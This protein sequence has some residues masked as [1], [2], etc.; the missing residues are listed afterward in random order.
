[1]FPSI[2]FHK[3]KCN[4][5][6]LG[7]AIYLGSGVAAAADTAT[8]E[9]ASGPNSVMQEVVV[10]GSHIKRAD[11]ETA[12]NVAVIS[13]AEVASSGQETVAD[14]LRTISSA[15]GN[16]SNESFSNSFAPGAASI[17]LRGLSG[18]DTLVL[19]NGR[20]ITNYGFFQNL[21]D[22]FVDLNIIPAAAIDHIEIL[23]SGGSAI[24]GSDA[25]TGVINVILKQN[26]TEKAVE[27]GD[28]VTTDGGANTRDA[29]VRFGIGD[30]ATQ[31]YNVFATG[32]VY[33]RDQLLF[34]QRRNTETQDYRNLPDGILQYHIAN[35]YAQ[36]KT[37]FPNCGTPAAPG[38]VAT[39]SFGP[40]CYYND[41][42]QLSLLPEA[43]RANVTVTGNL[44]LGEHWTGY[45]DLFFSNEETKNNFTPATLSNGSF[46]ASLANNSATQVSNVLPGT[47]RASI[48]GAPTSIIY[49]FQSV[50]GRDAEVVSNT[51]RVTFGAK[52]TF[53]GWDIDGAYGHSEN[54]VSFEAQNSINAAN[55]TADIANGSFN[56]LD[57]TQT[58]QANAALRVQN[59]F[60]SVAKLDSV[61]LNGSRNL[62]NL[63]GGPVKVAA[64]A[65]FRH[66]SV[67]DQPGPAE[68]AGI[69]LNNGA[70][71]VVA[72]RSIEAL[73]GEL[74]LPIVESL[75]LDVALRDEH[76][77]DVGTTPWRPQYT[78]RWQPLRAVT[79]RAVFADGFRAP[80]LAES[81][82]S[83][84][85]AN[86]TIN[87]PLD[88]AHRPTENVGLI[89]GG[90]P[91]V[92]PETSRNLDLGLIVSPI[93]NLDFSIDYYNIFLYDVIAPNATPQAIADN[94]AAYPGQLHRGPDGTIV[95]VEALYTNQFE[96][97]TS[98]LDISSNYSIPL[99]DG[100][101]K[102]GIDTT[103]VQHFQVNSAGTW[104]EFVGSNG[105]DYLSPIAGGG[106][107]PRWKGSL[108]SGWENLDWTGSVSLRYTQGYQ[109]S[110]TGQGITTQKTV[111]S[112]SSVD[113]D[114]QYRGLKDWKFTLSVVNLLNRY[115]PY[116]SAALLFTPSATPYD[117][118]TYDDL[119]RMISLH[120][121]RSF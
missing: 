66:E 41:A 19:L 4:A 96:I 95:Y 98:G 114:G 37:P 77:S 38:V 8:A 54:H 5:A 11:A 67:N 82:R 31:G 79:L 90:N 17:G 73:F 97:H 107:V 50:G 49:G 91:N 1:M 89:T 63:P 111:A 57:P 80:S 83:S 60:A 88:P 103:Y 81:S 22:A 26:T 120:V 74:D 32:S 53:A 69:V 87:D 9:E 112:Y 121:S 23:K 35:Q 6:F 27:V 12:V 59:T 13:A 16:N 117:S 70:T 75:D 119:G 109:N 46:V 92:K 64:G 45:S 85:V 76:Y 30:F 36:S 94:P 100:K 84:S 34:S 33:K 43:E 18:T 72:D 44:R 106:P 116:D 14:F 29:N 65:E 86:S 47:N 101:L 118:F 20:R 115:P 61:D 99:F 110:L 102:F 7:T 2:K 40:G 52:G 3:W 78:L 71:R 104:S 55:L 51:Y 10:T 62:F 56:F 21:S 28:R 24:Y 68:S 113:L 108:S 15:F 25:I 93:S 39:G 48:G 105:W 42:N 58:P